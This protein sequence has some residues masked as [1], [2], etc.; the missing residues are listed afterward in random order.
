MQS[1]AR[2]RCIKSGLCQSLH[3][4][5]LTRQCL[6][7]DKTQDFLCGIRQRQPDRSE[8]LECLEYSRGL[9]QIILLAPN[10]IRPRESL[11]TRIV[12]ALGLDILGAG[13]LRI[14]LFARTADPSR[15]M[16]R[17]MASCWPQTTIVEYCGRRDVV[18]GLSLS[19][20]DHSW[21][22]IAW[23]RFDGTMFRD[24]LSKRVQMRANE[25]WPF[26]AAERGI[27][28]ESNIRPTAV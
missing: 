3:Y 16:K 1:A 26:S 9:G 10:M 13:N 2:G 19:A 12:D 28:D 14:I 7:L 6:P 11:L 17:N 22:S 23:K 20:A 27:Y 15:W 25:D 8:Y 4:R 18:N 21:T 5:M 24:A